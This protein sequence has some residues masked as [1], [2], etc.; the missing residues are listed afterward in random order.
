MK[1]PYFFTWTK[2]KDAL[3]FELQKCDETCFYLTKYGKVFDLSSISYQTS[4]GLKNTFIENAIMEQLQKFAVASPKATFKLKNDVTQKLLDFCQKKT[5]KILYTTSGAESNEN[6]LKIARRIT[7]KKVILSRRVS[8]HGA[9]LGALSI[10][11]DWRRDH[12]LTLDEWTA[13]IPEAHKDPDCIETEN[14][15]KKVGPENIAGFFLETI[16]G[17][18]GVYMAPQKWWDGIKRLQKKYDLLLILDEVLTGFYRTG[19]PFGYF[20]YNLDP[21]IITFSKAISNGMIPFGATYVSQK[22]SDFFEENILSC[23]LTNYAHPLGLAALDAVL[24]ICKDQQFLDHYKLLQE[25]FNK[26]VL[27]M[28]KRPRV[29]EV[30]CIGM[31]AAIEMDN[32]PPLV[33]FLEKGLHFVI[34][35]KRII[36][37]PNYT[38]SIEKLNEA[39]DILEEV[40]EWKK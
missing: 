32:P 30:R 23:G 9:T 16:I 25:T 24:T 11:G 1:Y 36:L 40:M 20:H 10:S 34:H 27:D 12:N 2:Q 22:C 37:A 18:N 39:L 19:E 6:A 14:V 33:K 7:N 5:G 29:K 4:F 31:L 8:Y 21:D 3:N 17:G 26:R 28:A 35:A 38:Y 15:I 13:W